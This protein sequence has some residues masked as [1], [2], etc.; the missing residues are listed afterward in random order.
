VR[1][2]HGAIPVVLFA[3]FEV[4]DEQATSEFLAGRVM[5][6]GGGGQAAGGMPPGWMAI[7]EITRRIDEDRHAWPV[8]RTRLQKLAYFATVAGV[9]TGLEFV[10]GSYGPFARDLAKLLSRLVNNGVLTEERLGRMLAVRPGPAFDDA[11][12]RNREAIQ[13]YEPTI[14]RVTDLLAR[15]DSQRTEIAASVHFAAESLTGQLCRR[16]TEREVLGKV[17]Q[18]KQ[19][20]QPPVTDVEVVTAIRDLAALGWVQVTPSAELPPDDLVTVA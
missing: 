18:W 10:E 6:V 14:Q 17:R 16:P 9:P 11:I 19:R 2:S 8:G 15:L 7:A 5:P 4:A 3:P 20:R 1:R 13:P 12:A